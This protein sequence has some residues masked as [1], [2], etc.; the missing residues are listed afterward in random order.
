MEVC[1]HFALC[2]P[3]TSIRYVLCTDGGFVW[4]PAF[5]DGFRT[6]LALFRPGTGICSTRSGLGF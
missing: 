1:L 4:N 2:M 3:S 6:L 5:P